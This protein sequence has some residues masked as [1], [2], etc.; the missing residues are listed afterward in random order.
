MTNR[1]LIFLLG[2]SAG[3]VAGWG[4]KPN[5]IP[6]EP[7]V[8]AKLPVKVPV[9]MAQANPRPTEN[10]AQAPAD[11]RIA[12]L[13]QKLL[14]LEALPTLPERTAALQKE[15]GNVTPQNA[16]LYQSAWKALVLENPDGNAHWGLL[17]RKLGQVVGAQVVGKRTGNGGSDLPGA[18][19]YVKD[20]F[21]GWMDADPKAAQEWFAK[22][23]NEAFQ[24]ALLEVYSAES[25]E[26][27]RSPQSTIP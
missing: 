16:L 2:A 4:L 7:A 3:G 12:E 20:Q 22:L 6:P 21:S 14:P 26:S 11:P 1:A 15:F 24:S 5:P 18:K 9:E 23:K 17:N 25:A 13:K 10:P 19:T 27:P 8:P